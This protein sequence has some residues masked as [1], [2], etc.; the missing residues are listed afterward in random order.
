MA[1]TAIAF[2]LLFVYIAQFKFSVL[3]YFVT[4]F[5]GLQDSAVNNLMNC[6]LGFEFESKILPFSVFKFVSSLFTFAFYGVESFI[7]EKRDYLIYAICM[8]VLSFSSLGL[9][10]SFKFRKKGYIDEERK[11]LV[12]K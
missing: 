5:W 10:Y 8:L 2:A 12:D 11:D 1:Q 7:K 9:M 3:A 6:I 4:L